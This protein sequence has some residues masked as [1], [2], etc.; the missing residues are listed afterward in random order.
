MI[1]ASRPVMSVRRSSSAFTVSPSA[2]NVSSCRFG[3][4]TPLPKRSSSVSPPSVA[5]TVPT[6]TTSAPTAPWL[7]VRLLL[8]TAPAAGVAPPASPSKF[9]TRPGLSSC[10]LGRL[11]G[12]ASGPLFVPSCAPFCPLTPVTPTPT[13]A[14]AVTSKFFFLSLLL[15]S[16]QR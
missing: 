14:W 11:T 1:T 10:F 12:N 4:P 2:K 16:F 8:S 5:S 6:S 3:T 7:L 13:W 15:W 9:A